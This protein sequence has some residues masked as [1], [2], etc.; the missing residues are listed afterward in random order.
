MVELMNSPSPDA[1]EQ[2]ATLRDLLVYQGDENTANIVRHGI[3]EIQSLRAKL[4]EKKKEFVIKLDEKTRQWNDTLNLVGRYEKE[5]EV[6]KSQLEAIRKQTV[7][8]CKNTLRAKNK[9]VTFL[10]EAIF[11][12]DALSHSTAE[13]E[14]KYEGEWYAERC[15]LK[16]HQ[17]KPRSVFET[18]EKA[19][20]YA[21]KYG[22]KWIVAPSDNSRGGC[23]VSDDMDSTSDGERG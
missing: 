21:E 19:I 4:A 22:G 7:E 10:D 15:D 12:L 23:I 5:N 18:K 17:Y 3:R 1:I 9:Y 20:A 8:E 13:E 11:S 14:S 2:L 16:P 6:L